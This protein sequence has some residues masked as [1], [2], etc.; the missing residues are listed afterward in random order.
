[1]EE[2]SNLMVDLVILYHC[3]VFRVMGGDPNIQSITRYIKA[4]LTKVHDLENCR[5]VIN[6]LLVNRPNFLTLL[7]IPNQLERFGPIRSLWEGGEMGEGSIKQL[8]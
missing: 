5:S 1:M 8:K 2:V 6:S 3:F 4:F 7:N